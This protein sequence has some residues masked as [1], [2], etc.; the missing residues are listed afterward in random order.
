MFFDGFMLVIG[1]DG[2]LSESPK[3]IHR[4][5]FGATMREPNESDVK[6]LCHM[7]GMGCRMRGVLIK[8]K[9]KGRVRIAGAKMSKEC[10][11]IRNAVTG[12]LQKQAVSRANVDCVEEDA[13]RVSSTDRYGYSCAAWSPLRSQGGKEEN[14]SFVFSENGRIRAQMAKNTPDTLFFSLPGG[15]FPARSALASKRSPWRAV[16]VGWCVAQPIAPFGSE[17]IPTEVG[18]STLSD[19]TRILVGCDSMR[20]AGIEPVDHRAPLAVPRHGGRPRTVHCAGREIPLSTGKPSFSL[21][22][23]FAQ[24]SQRA[25]RRPTQA[26]PVSVGLSTHRESNANERATDRVRAN[27]VRISAWQASLANGGAMPVF[28]HQKVCHFLWQ[29]T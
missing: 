11:E 26:A 28:P 27:S 6:P 22:E 17:P 29:P 10:D 13:L 18:W 23:P 2:L 25:H 19:K 24:Q 4:I 9:S 5:E 3:M 15:L 16:R 14:V 7:L 1:A 8:Q 20:H 21:L 12:A